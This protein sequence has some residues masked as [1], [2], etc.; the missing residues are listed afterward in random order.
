MI[1]EKGGT[2]GYRDT[3]IQ[4]NRETGIQG[5]RD[6]GIQGYRDKGIQ[7]YRDT[8]I[9]IYR[10]AVI[11]GNRDTWIQEYRD[12][13]IQGYRDTGIQGYRNTRTSRA[14]NLDNFFLVEFNPIWT[15]VWFFNW[16][17]GKEGQ[18]NPFLHI[19]FIMFLKPLGLYLKYLPKNGKFAKIQ[20]FIAKSRN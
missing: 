10:D 9:Q 18:F 4:G 14:G 7:R 20:I 11:Q 16:C 6:T 1:Q 12:T 8:R 13:G 2:Q 17:P 5:Y 3:G 19:L 15:D